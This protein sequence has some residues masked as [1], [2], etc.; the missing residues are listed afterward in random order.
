MV[1]KTVLPG[2]FTHSGMTGFDPG[3]VRSTFVPEHP[4]SAFPMRLFFFGR[5]ALEGESICPH[6]AGTIRKP[7][8]TFIRRLP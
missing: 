3:K 8:T 2:F 1:A 7:L 5:L 4:G 6:R